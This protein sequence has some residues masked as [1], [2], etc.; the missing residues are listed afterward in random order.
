MGRDI[1]AN[2]FSLSYNPRCCFSIFRV[3][4]LRV[5]NPHFQID[6]VDAW[7][8]LMA[9]I[10]MFQLG[11]MEFTNPMVSRLIKLVFIIWVSA[12][13]TNF[14]SE[15]KATQK[16]PV[17]ATYALPIGVVGVSL[18]LT[19][20]TPW[21]FTTSIL[22]LLFSLFVFDYGQYWWN[23]DRDLRAKSFCTSKNLFIRWMMG[24]KGTNGWGCLLT[25]LAYGGFIAFLHLK[26][27]ASYDIL[28]ALS[29]FPFVMLVTLL[30]THIGLTLAFGRRS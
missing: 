7:P 19:Q 27:K 15:V 11:H 22:S 6:A 9:S 25:A 1:C 18:I 26:L 4:K 10:A 30:L 20:F 12:Q 13:S 21:S 3:P 2:K 16:A 8:P 17:A 29:V 14:Y 28:G 23:G 5:L 24:I